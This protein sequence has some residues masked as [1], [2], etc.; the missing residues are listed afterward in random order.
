MDVSPG[1]VVV[2]NIMAVAVLAIGL[3]EYLDW[4]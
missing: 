1:F 3:S 4:F 2:M